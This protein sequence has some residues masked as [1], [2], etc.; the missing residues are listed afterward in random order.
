MSGTTAC[1]RRQVRPASCTFRRARG[2][3]QYGGCGEPHQSACGFSCHTEKFSTAAKLTHPE[4][5]QNELREIQRQR[6]SVCNEATF[7]PHEP[8]GDRDESVEHA[9][10]RTEHLGG[11]RPRR[12]LQFCIERC[13]IDRS[14]C[15]DTCSSSGDEE[16]PEKTNDLSWHRASPLSSA[17]PDQEF[18]AVLLADKIEATQVAALPIHRGYRPGES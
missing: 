14:Q 7:A 2:I 16:P 9:P 13:R 5:I 17:P 8:R 4:G 18:L 3:P 10:H 15:A 12:P 1:L 11:R 6:A